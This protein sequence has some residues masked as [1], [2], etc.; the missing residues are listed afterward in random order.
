[1]KEMAIGGQQKMARPDEAEHLIHTINKAT[2][3]FTRVLQA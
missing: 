2:I 1:M 3:L